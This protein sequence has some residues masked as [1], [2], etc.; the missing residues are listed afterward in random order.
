MHPEG[1]MKARDIMTANPVA[2]VPGDSIR[3]AADVMRE[4]NIGAVPVVDDFT[5]KRL[6][7][8]ITDRDIVIRC[9]AEGHSPFCLVS[10]H[11][12]AM[13]LE[14]VGPEAK[15]SE[16]IEKM[17]VAQVRRIPVVGKNAEI[18][19]VIAQADIATK[20]GPRQPEQVEEMIE[21]ISKAPVPA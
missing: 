11:M 15:V 14:T 18:L 2:V 13:P 20:V 8:I 17:E 10:E 4:L 9:T 5:T 1:T 16:V 6:R 12:S 21:R 3:E 19:G 7:G